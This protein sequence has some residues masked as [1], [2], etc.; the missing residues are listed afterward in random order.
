MIV[1]SLVFNRKTRFEILL[2][3]YKK[4]FSQMVMNL[5]VFY[6]LGDKITKCLLG[7]LQFIYCLKDFAIRIFSEK[8][9][10]LFKKLQHFFVLVKLMNTTP[11]LF[12]FTLTSCIGFKVRDLYQ[13]IAT[14]IYNLSSLA[15]LF[16]SRKRGPL[17]KEF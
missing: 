13:D 14:L 7:R 6:F 3:A 4:K 15:S 1:R 12:R 10:L 5:F 17:A 2:D 16:E 9:F 8:L 11:R